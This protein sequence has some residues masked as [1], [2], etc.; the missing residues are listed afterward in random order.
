MTLN[1][2]NQAKI[3]TTW[4]IEH[5]QLSLVGHVANNIDPSVINQVTHSNQ[6]SQ[7]ISLTLLESAAR[8]IE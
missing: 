6:S 7:H 1:I 8:L 3:N 4:L 2:N 5:P